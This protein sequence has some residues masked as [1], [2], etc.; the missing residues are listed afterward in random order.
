MPLSLFRESSTWENFDSPRGSYSPL[1]RSS[2]RRALVA[3]SSFIFR[4][5]TRRKEFHSP[6]GSSNPVTSIALRIPSF[7]FSILLP[8][9]FSSDIITT[10][11]FPFPLVNHLCL[12]YPY[13]F[14]FFI[15]LTQL[16]C[17]TCLVYRSL[18]FV[19]VLCLP[20]SYLPAFL[21]ERIG[22]VLSSFYYF[23]IN[24]H[25]HIYAANKQILPTIA[26]IFY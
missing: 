3:P 9:F 22:A 20:S 13:P 10:F 4:A 1:N 14:L 19:P 12:T 26:K 18:F 25:W 5:K 7:F 21:A 6:A 15:L 17:L 11:F 16:P 2:S 24:P 23:N 8:L